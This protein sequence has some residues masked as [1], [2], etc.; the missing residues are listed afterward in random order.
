MKLKKGITGFGSAKELL[1]KPFVDIALF[2]SSLY[3][4]EYT[5]QFKIMDFKDTEINTNYS[6]VAIKDKLS[7]NDFDI[8]VNNYYPYYCGV[9][10]H[11][12]WM[13]FT[14]IDLPNEIRNCLDEN[15]EY[16]TTTD[17]NLRVDDENLSELSEPEL[18]QIK[19]WKSKTFGEIIF[20]GYD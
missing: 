8:L 11:S 2:K 14:F 6:R 5:G 12:A 15:F 17:L 13:N 10:S 19:Y 3:P 18:K 7:N 1:I 20:N 9:T 4:I 16:L